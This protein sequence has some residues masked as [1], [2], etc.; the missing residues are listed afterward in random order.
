[1]AN[2][3]MYKKVNLHVVPT[4]STLSAQMFSFLFQ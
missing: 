4:E 1:M 3:I 2:L